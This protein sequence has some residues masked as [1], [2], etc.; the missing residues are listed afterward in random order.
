M[1]PQDA[2]VLLPGVLLGLHQPGRP[3]DADEEPPGPR[4]RWGGIKLVV[5]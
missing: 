3:L 4:G 5:R 2:D 1:E